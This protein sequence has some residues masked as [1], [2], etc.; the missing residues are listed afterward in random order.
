MFGFLL[1]PG[2]VLLHVTVVAAVVVMVNLGLWQLRRHHERVDFN[3]VVAERMVSAPTPLTTVLEKIQT[4]E[5]SPSEAEWLN[6]SVQ[7]RYIADQSLLSVNRSQDGISGVDPLTPL[8]LGGDE[9]EETILV[10]RGFVGQNAKVPEPPSGELEIIAR[11]R[12]SESRR[13]GQLSDPAAG[14]LSEVITI[15]L[16]RLAAQIENLNTEIYLEVLESRPSEADYLARIA[17]PNL[18]SGPHLS[19]TVQ[20][21][22]FSIFVIAGWVVVVRRKIGSGQGRDETL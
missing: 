22:I 11:V 16:P 17:S 3:K 19:Y 8:V 15:D 21:F 13:L 7:G 1:R 12:L 14:I 2:W 9:I 6:V 10:N 18:T 20:W 4:G 5:L